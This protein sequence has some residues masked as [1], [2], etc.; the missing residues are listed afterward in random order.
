MLNPYW[1]SQDEAFFNAAE[2]IRQ[3]AEELILSFQQA[4]QKKKVKI[5]RIAEEIRLDEEG[6]VH[7]GPPLAAVDKP[8]L[9][10]VL[11]TH[12]SFGVFFTG[13]AWS[14]DGSQIATVSCNY[15]GVPSTIQVWGIPISGGKARNIW[16]KTSPSRSSGQGIAWSP[17]GKYIASGE[18]EGVQVWDAATGNELFRYDDA[19][20]FIS[21][22]MWS[23]NGSRFAF[24]SWNGIQI[25]N[26]STKTHLFTRPT[27]EDKLI[28]SAEHM[29]WSPDSTYLASSLDGKI[30]VCQAV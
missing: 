14:P 1:H 16:R 21:Y 26:T 28:R 24:S 7:V 23:P 30:D 12:H 17:D 11:Y 10:T 15:E 6:P 25:W 13:I 2:G 8:P 20:G 18:R 29:A 4:T 9:G 5:L 19:D 22:V 27:D 3:A